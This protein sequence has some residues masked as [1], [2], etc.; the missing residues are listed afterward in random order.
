MA[1]FSDYLKNI[2]FIILLL[3][4]APPLLKNIKNQYANL[5][6]PQTKVGVLT[7]KGAILDSNYYT[8]YLRK[9]F[10]DCDIKAILLKIESPGG[11]AGSSEAISHEIELLKKECPKPIISL[12]ENICASGGYY[13]AA[14]TDYIIAPPSALI[15]SIGTY[16]PFQF[17]LKDFIEHYKITYNVIKAGDYKIATDPF[18]NPTPELNSMLQ[19]VADD[20]YKNFTHYVAKHRTK[21]SLDNVKEWANGKIFTGS[22]AQKLGIIDELGSYSDAIKIIKDKAIIEGKIEWVQPQRQGGLLGMLSGNQDTAD[23]DDSIISNAVNN[24]CLTLEERYGNKTT[25]Q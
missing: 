2:F 15:G 9:Y 6:E 3:Q 1:T 24:I 8:K 20:S 4:F 10:H 13:I 21:L 19:S 22:Q 23:N 18:V 11:A 5:L 14:S 25:I 12:V 17:K 16:I 7:I